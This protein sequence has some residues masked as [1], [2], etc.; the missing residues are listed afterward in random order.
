MNV[1]TFLAGLLAAGGVAAVMADDIVVCDQADQAI[2]IYDGS[3]VIWKWT[4]AA[5]PVIPKGDKAGFAGNVADCK[6]Y[7]GGKTIAMVACGSRWAVIDRKAKK[8]VAWGKNAG[9]GHSIELLPDDIVAVV[10]TGG[11]NGSAV[12][13]FD[14]KGEAALDPSKQKGK[15]F[16]FDMPHGL[17][18]D[19]GAK[20]LYVVDTPGLHLC[21][22]GRN[23][24]GELVLE[25]E[26]TWAFKD[27]GVIH[28]HDLRPVPRT[29]Q[30][31]MTTHEK[32]LF[33]DMKKGDWI[34]DLFIVR[35]DVKAFDPAA[36]GKRF[37]VSVAKTKW[38]TD[39][40]EICT[41]DP[42]TKG[43]GFENLRTFP[44]AKIYKA[45]WCPSVSLAEEEKGNRA[46]HPYGD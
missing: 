21:K 42:K 41:R 2:K 7:D 37:L 11:D 39:T 22:A 4:G 26:K 6:A 20:K 33:F 43:W 45:R 28:G 15:R 5:D 36:D 14:I 8:A 38:W 18:W 40:L 30:L 10:S 35:Q 23:K 12:F 34:K 1:K 24:E 3:R 32:I 46:D 17:H 16:P 31:V 25:V 9:W 27:L 44:G 19:S 29:S 13:L